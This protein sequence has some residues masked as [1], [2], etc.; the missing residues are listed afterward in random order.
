MDFEGNKPSIN[1]GNPTLTKYSATIVV[2]KI[3]YVLLLI[4]LISAQS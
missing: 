2:I 3:K 1:R 4:V